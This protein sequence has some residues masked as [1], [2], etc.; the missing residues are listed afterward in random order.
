[1]NFF[2]RRSQPAASKPKE[3]PPASNGGSGGN[4]NATFVAVSKMKETI[5]NMN[6]RRV[7][8][9][10]RSKTVS[11]MRAYRNSWKKRWK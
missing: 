2:G 1:M 9:L 8:V 10:Y 3:A 6:K 5:T 11:L 7:S 4:T